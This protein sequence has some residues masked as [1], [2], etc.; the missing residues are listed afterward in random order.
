MPLASL[1]FSAICKA[2]TDNHFAS[3]HFFSLGVVFPVPVYSKAPL[4]IVYSSAPLVQEA[5]WLDP[6]PRRRPGHYLFQ[7]PWRL[8]WE[9]QPWPPVPS[10]VPLFPVS[11]Q[12]GWKQIPAFP[13]FPL[14]SEPFD[15]AHPAFADTMNLTAHLLGLGGH[16]RQFHQGDRP[17]FS[18]DPVKG[19]C[20]SSFGGALRGLSRPFPSL[21][22]TGS[23]D[24]DTGRETGPLPLRSHSCKD[25][26]SLESL[27]AIFPLVGRRLA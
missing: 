1:L 23:S 14:S 19:G 3:L 22:L 12:K 6:E 20:I 8:W 7:G 9:I 21:L 13:N 24:M 10:D 15:L 4:S 16:G 18:P 26:L 5:A 17:S 2:F 27:V 11:D 25:Q